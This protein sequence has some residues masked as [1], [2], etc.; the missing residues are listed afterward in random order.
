[1]YLENLEY[2]RISIVSNW[3]LKI[4]FLLMS[5]EKIK[6]ESKLIPLK[7]MENLLFVLVINNRW[8]IG[9][10]QL[11]C[12]KIVKFKLDNH[13]LLVAVHLLLIPHL[14]LVAVFMFLLNKLILKSHKL[15][16]KK[17]S[18]KK[19]LLEKKMEEL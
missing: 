13:H 17:K 9:L 18:L 2:G 15:K 1:M 6:M 19:K 11:F 10:L 14:L 4:I 12:L 5:L 7:M 16:E 8:M 3:S